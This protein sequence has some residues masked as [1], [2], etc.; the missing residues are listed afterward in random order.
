MKT[1]SIWK[2]LAPIFI[3]SFILSS[4]AA[5]E[6]A[7]YDCTIDFVGSQKIKGD[8]KNKA[9][10]VLQLDEVRGAF[11]DKQFIFSTRGRVQSQMLATALTAAAGGFEV[12]ILTDLDANETPP[13]I[14]GITLVTP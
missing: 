14:S 7:W 5:A 10:P 6:E 3:T 9:G 2:S 12:R 4:N 13:R 1:K 11:L 8:K